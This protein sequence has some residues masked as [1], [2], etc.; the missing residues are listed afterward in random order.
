MRS[1]R[2]NILQIE[3]AADGDPDRVRHLIL[4]S[5]GVDH[6]AALGIAPGDVQKR[7]S[8]LF[9]KVGSEFL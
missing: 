2:A 9:I 3:T 5:A 8:Q 4:G 6:P 7:L 1:Y